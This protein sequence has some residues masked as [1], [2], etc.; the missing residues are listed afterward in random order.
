MMVERSHLDDFDVLHWFAENP[1]K[2][3]SNPAALE[4]LRKQDFG[5]RPWIGSP[6]DRRVGPHPKRWIT[7]DRWQES[8]WDSLS[9]YLCELVDST[10]GPHFADLLIGYRLVLENETPGRNYKNLPTKITRKKPPSRNDA[11]ERNRKLKRLGR[12]LGAPVTAHPQRKNSLKLAIYTA[13]VNDLAASGMPRKKACEEQLPKIWDAVGIK[14]HP[15]SI[16][17]MERRSRQKA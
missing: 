3:V 15:A 16:L 5:W 8:F 7:P 17:R 6:L 13:M 1:L 14:V 11:K 4:V 9:S 2:C 10:L 12:I